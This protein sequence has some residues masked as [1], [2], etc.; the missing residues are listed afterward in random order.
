MGIGGLHSTEESRFFV[1][2][3]NYVLRD[4][5]VA[6]YYPS[7][8]LRTEIVPEQI[9]ASFVHN[10]TS[11]YK[12]RLDA[13]RI[14]N[15]KIADSLKTL[16][17]GTFGKL[18]SKHSIFYAPAEL[19][20]VTI[21]GQLA[22][23]M[24]IEQL[25]MAGISVISANTDGIVLYCE[26]RLEWIADSIIKAWELITR[27][28]TERTDYTG[29]YSR[30][31]NSYIAIEPNGS[32]KL[33][34]AFA[35]AE[36][37]ASGW[38]NPTG[39]ICVDAIIA[40]LRDGIP[41]EQTIYSCADIRKFIYARAVRGGGVLCNRPFLPKKT[42]KKEQARL[43]AAYDCDNYES[44][45]AW[46]K[47]DTEYLGKVVRWYYATGSTGHIRYQT[48][49]NMVP[50]SNGCKPCMQLPVMLPADIDYTWYINET[51]SLLKE[52]DYA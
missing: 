26:R 34:G 29:V 35:P 17:N 6:S 41:I 28:E 25:E 44:L 38:P 2:N 46:S 51:K 9:G 20:Q 11:W 31:V 16:L 52:V 18:G 13:K 10:Y 32:V 42:T 30:D 37:G 19:I 47:G 24:L 36:P 50:R 40:Y 12:R 22:I 45:Y 7:L 27:F 48:S 33:K 39:Q 5:D 23:L 43:L 15:K 49:G 8:I 21:T 14:G 4:H 3:E 1:S